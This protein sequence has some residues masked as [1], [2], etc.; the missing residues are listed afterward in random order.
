MGGIV[1]INLKQ[2]ILNYSSINLK[3]LAADEAEIPDGIKNSITLYN[4][5]IES[6]RTD[7]EDIA[8]IELKKAI[9]M[10]PN[11]HE[12]MNLLGIC[13]SHTKEYVK[14]AETF[15][16]VI[17]AENNSIKALKYLGLMNSNE[18][19]GKAIDSKN[20]SYNNEV[21]NTKVKKSLSILDDVVNLKRNWKVDL[22]KYIIGFLL[23]AIIVAIFAF[24]RYKPE[25][26]YITSSSNA[27]STSTSDITSTSDSTSSN[28]ENEK[29]AEELSKTQSDLKNAITQID[30]YKNSLKLYEIDTLLTTKNYETAADMLVLLK[31][32]NFIEPEKEKF[33]NLYSVIM[34]KAASKLKDEAWLLYKNKKYQEAIDKLT[35]IQLYGDSS[36]YMDFSYYCMGRCFIGLNDSMRAVEA[37]EKIISTYPDSQYIRYAKNRIKELKSIQ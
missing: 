14:A 30:Y 29:I 37:F 25:N 7:N 11:F 24:I 2:E 31:S 16:K 17:A 10:N 23:C 8:I 19:V 21:Y 13:Y 3:S 28:A 27:D 22:K 34:N 5:A 15:E 33:D 6:I 35:K 32:V 4:K 20:R 1:L 36:T 9:S 12:A 18:T 26:D